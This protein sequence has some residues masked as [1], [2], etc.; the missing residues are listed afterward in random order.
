MLS[1]LLLP[2][3]PLGHCLQGINEEGKPAVGL[4]GQENQMIS[5]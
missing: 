1:L 2:H 3:I 5:H 4:A